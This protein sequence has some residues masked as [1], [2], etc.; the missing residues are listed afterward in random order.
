[1]PAARVDFGAATINRHYISCHPGEPRIMVQPADRH[2]PKVLS[3]AMA[4]GLLPARDFAHKTLVPEAGKRWLAGPAG[5][6]EVT[7]RGNQYEG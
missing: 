2:G 3:H 7:R 4:S 1:M 6:V 5:W